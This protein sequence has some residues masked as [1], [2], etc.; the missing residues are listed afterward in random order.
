MNK[1]TP[2]ILSLALTGVL[3]L[4]GCSALEDNPEWIELVNGPRNPYIHTLHPITLDN[5]Y[6]LQSGKEYSVNDVF[7]IDVEEEKITTRLHVFWSGD[8]EDINA[9]IIIDD[10]KD[11]F[12][13]E[14]GT[15]PICIIYTVDTPV[16][17][18]DYTCSAQFTV[19]E[20]EQ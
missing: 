10:E 7:V 18:Y 13:I 12:I 11:T 2:K 3:C 15:G 6:Q 19:V 14:E 5:D 8:V 16:A 17:S 4:S 9:G 20:G 1:L